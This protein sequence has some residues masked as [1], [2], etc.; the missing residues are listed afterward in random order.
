MAITEA[1]FDNE[2]EL[3]R[4]IKAEFSVFIPLS[5]VLD[6]FSVSTSSGKRGIPDGF[7]FDFDGRQWYVIECELLKHG[8]WPHIAEQVTRFVVAMKNPSTLRTV[9]D[10]VFEHVMASG[11]AN[12]VAK[13]LGSVPERLLQQIELFVEGLRPQFVIFID[14]TNKDLQDMADALDAP[15][16]IFRVQKFLVD[17][18]P[19]YHSPDR[20]LPAI[21]SE[22]EDSGARGATEYQVIEMLGGGELA[23]QTGRFKCYR[24]TDGSII[25][26]KKS[27]YHSRQNY[28]WY[29]IAPAVL[30]H[31]AEFGV[32]HVVFIMSDYGFVRVP[33]ET[34][35]EYV[36]HT[37]ATRH[38]DGSVRHYHFLISH[39]AEPELYWSSEQPKYSLAEHFSPFE[40]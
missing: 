27:K 13:Q 7:A 39:D 37:K 4:W 33:I 8:V 15:T 25:H 21:V 34:V 12:D 2:K 22:P 29:G 10:R 9:R 26:V 17:G 24:L 19:E 35:T 16:M 30:G 28:Y 31:F 18:R 11:K 5:F 20:N 40:Q 32:T 1:D 3:E 23:G 6:G 36:K 38:S 14:R